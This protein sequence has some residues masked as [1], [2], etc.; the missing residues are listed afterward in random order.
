MAI[1][2]FACLGLIVGSFLNVVLLR[3]ESGQSFVRGRS[4]CP[5]CGGSI[6]WYDNLPL[7]SFLFLGGRCRH[8]RGAISW[9]YPIIEV[10]TGILF[11]TPAWLVF[12]W[13]D[14][15]ASVETFWWC[16]FFSILLLIAVYDLRTME[17]PV[18][19]L[20][21]GLAGAVVYLVLRAFFFESDPGRFLFSHFVAGSVPAGLFWLLVALSRERWMGRGDIW[22]GL[23][24][25][26]AVGLPSILLFLTLASSIG[27]VVGLV[28]V[29]L[30]RKKLDTAVPFGPYLALGAALT[31]VLG[32][33]DPAWLALFLLPLG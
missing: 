33:L 8:C 2:F 3:T 19:F 22:L 7:L 6:V 32:A 23:L 28:L 10:A 25:G 4:K 30:Q 16:F 20:I 24:A 26:L 29:G 5:R 11:A 12:E 17:I 31:L 14:T 9:Q 18:S 21:F 15:R 27:A 1:F 13:G